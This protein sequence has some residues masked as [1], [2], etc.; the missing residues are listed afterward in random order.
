MKIKTRLTIVIETEAPAVMLQKIAGNRLAQ[1]AFAAQV[2]PFLG[3]VNITRM[4]VE[5]L[6]Q[7]ATTF[8]ELENPERET[9]PAVHQKF[10]RPDVVEFA[11]YMNEAMES[12]KG[13][14]PDYTQPEYPMIDAIDCFMDKCDQ[15][16]YNIFHR[17]DDPITKKTLV[18]LANFCMIIVWKLAH[19]HKPQP[20]AMQ[21]AA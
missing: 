17:P 18:H 14:K 2:Q 16:K 13:I 8:G 7:P 6:T 21:S 4:T 12:K 19:G 9:T 10:L 3:A 1:S 20:P 15:A 11:G 5:D